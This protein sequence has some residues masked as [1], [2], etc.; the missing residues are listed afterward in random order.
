MR[1][2]ER[3]GMGDHPFDLLVSR[4]QGVFD[5][6]DNIVD[7]VDRFACGEAAMIMDKQPF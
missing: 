7:H 3:L 1:L 4:L 2:A 5:A 6:V